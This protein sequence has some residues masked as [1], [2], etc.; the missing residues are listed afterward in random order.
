MR[1]IFT[2]AGIPFWFYEEGSDEGQAFLEEVG[3]VGGRLPV[4]AFYTGVVLEDPSNATSSQHW[5]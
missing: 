3:A 5:G 4:V 1:D 2:R